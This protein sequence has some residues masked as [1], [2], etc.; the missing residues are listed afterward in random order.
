MGKRKTAWLVTGILALAPLAYGMGATALI[1]LTNYKVM[2]RIPAKRGIALTFDDG[3]HPVYTLR[4]LDLLQQYDIKATFF[5]VGEKVRMY[6]KIIERMYN[7]GHQIGIHHDRHTSSWLL[8]P[9]QLEKEIRETHRAISNVI[10]ESPTVYRPPWGFMNAFTLYYSKPYQ[11]VFWTHVFQDWKVER[12]EDGLLDGLRNVPANGSIILL[13]DDGT[14]PGADD[15]APVHMLDKLEIYL[16]E[17]VKKET[18]FVVVPPYNHI[19]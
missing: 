2:K 19:K 15:L 18:E 11:I 1:R 6:P 14:N 3:P 8:T 10:G 7:E 4:L 12:C 13:H 17:A 16:E 9:S 5:V